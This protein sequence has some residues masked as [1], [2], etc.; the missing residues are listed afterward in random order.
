MQPF[1]HVASAL[2]FWLAAASIAMAQAAS[3]S[4]QGP[5]VRL[6]GDDARRAAG[7]D[8]AVNAAIEGDRLDEAISKAEALLALRT[9]VQGSKH[10][11]TVSA[12]WRVRTLRRVSSLPRADRDAYRTA[13]TA[14]AKG[15]ALFYKAKYAEA[16]SEFVRVLEIKRRLLGEGFPETASACHDLAF[17]LRQRARLEPSYKL[18]EEALALRRRL[19]GEDHDETADTYGVQAGTLDDLARYDD[20]RA[21]Y[22]KEVAIR[23]RL[24]GDDDPRVATAC[25]NLGL[26]L[27]HQGKPAEAQARF[28]QALAIRQRNPRG[29]E[30][31]IA[32]TFSNVATALNA[33][34]DLAGA[35]VHFERSLE[36]RRRL[37][38]DDDAET[39][40]GYNN[41]AYNLNSQGRYAEAQPLFEKA[42]EIRRRR[43]TDLHLETALSYNNLGFNLNAQGKYAQAQPAYERA[44]EIYRRILP[45]DH[46]DI[47]RVYNNLAYNLERQYQ[48][49]AARPLFEKALEI[50]RRKLTEDHPLTALS[51]ENLA[52]NFQ[53]AGDPSRARELH[54]KARGIR[55]RR[56]GEHHP[57]VAQSDANLGQDLAELGRFAEA[58]A[59]FE[60]ALRTY[61]EARGDDHPDTVTAWQGLGAAL[62]AQGKYAEARDA[63]RSS[64]SGFDRARLLAAFTGLERSEA[65]RSMR[66]ALAA[67]QARLG[68]PTAAWQTLE[69]D[70]GRG[71]LD[72][73]AARADRRMTP[74]ERTRL[75][76]L[77]AELERLD[78]LVESLPREDD[79]ARRAS[80]YDDLRRR[81]ELASIALGEF[82]AGLF[83]AR[84]VAAGRVAGLDELQRSLPADVALVAWV[85]DN[86]DGPGAADPDGEHWGVVVRSVGPPRWIRLKGCGP[87]GHWTRQDTELPLRVRLALQGRPGSKPAGPDGGGGAASASEGILAD[88]LRRLR[89]QRMDPLDRALGA[90][91]AGAPAPANALPPAR[92]LVVLPSRAVTGIPVE[93]L[94]GPGDERTVSYAPSSTVFKLLRERRRPDRHAGLLALG[95]PD[96][97]RPSPPASSDPGRLPDHGLL[98]DRVE[99]GSNAA[100]HD[101][102]PGD[103]LLSYNGVALHA[104]RD[105]KVV[106]GPP[107]QKVPVVIWREGVEVPGAVDPGRLSLVTDARPARV[108]LAERRG[109]Q[110]LL[111]AV[112]SGGGVLAPLPG[113][114]AEVQAIARVFAEDGRPVRLLLGREAGEP[115]VE[116][117][118]ASGDLARFGYLH[119]ATHGII[120]GQMPERS[121]VILSQADLPDP[122]TQAMNHRPVLDG[123]LSMQQIRAEWDLD[124]E[125]VALSACETALGRTAG[126]EGLV[127]FTQA[128]LLAGSRSVLV[129]QWKVDDRATA[130]LMTRFYQNLLGRRAGLPAPLP[131]AEALREA[132]QWLRRLSL[133][134]VGVALGSVE[135]GVVRPLVD[136]DP[137]AS[138]DVL[139]QS[140][141][142]P[143]EHPYFWAA[144]VLVGDPD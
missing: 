144:F 46:P 138:G 34:G 47:A 53:L 43:F 38:G 31:E 63:W 67:V 73:L 115:Q 55:V 109:L 12:D 126:G 10:P 90:A 141:P 129:S 82:Q 28:E 104:D 23:R 54:E 65:L 106:A 24:G 71:L 83:K 105:L 62:H 50:R 27:L 30:R 120:D 39:G 117:L 135:R 61:R 8:R 64:L 89:A 58:Q 15:E 41:L 133:D 6:A 95:D 80:K 103:V 78:R 18:G 127:G 107:G 33:R 45:A 130:L 94:L 7:L 57:S 21:Y 5:T 37:F 134:E 119:L 70:L 66:P 101:I 121:A 112:R 49:A 17:V 139:T 113:T 132:K 96:F 86:P 14:S 60:R 75:R 4:G 36:L 85:D 99:P 20:A 32:Q 1:Q 97:G 16:E 100:K 118:A 142:R 123:R 124:A 143:Y 122:L 59:S 74:A 2:M 110:E 48:Y 26:C 42:L 35:Q 92:R 3:S 128:L 69:E 137:R 51:Y 68:N 114:R 52:R 81:R 102:R 131:K 29:Q 44:L 13:M 111:L 116:G 136:K 84:G 72:E 40:Q 11:E 87:D 98:V 9:R 79:Q 88:L 19:L 108:A 76:E 25:N 125:L 93:A 22:E 91:D 140:G 56:L 77:T